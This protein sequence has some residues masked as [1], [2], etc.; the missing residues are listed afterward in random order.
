MRWRAKPP[1]LSVAAL[2]APSSGNEDSPGY[3]CPASAL[4][5]TKQQL[6]A[7]RQDR[8]LVEDRVG[9]EETKMPINLPL[10]V[11]SSSGGVRPP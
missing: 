3:Q 4:I 1:F 11:F 10:T 2:V 6:H 7:G 5:S 9:Y 8:D